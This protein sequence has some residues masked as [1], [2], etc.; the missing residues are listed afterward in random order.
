MSRG[1]QPYADIDPDELMNHLQENHRLIQPMNC[2]DSLYAI[3]TIAMHSSIHLLSFIRRFKIMSFCWTVS[4]DQRPS[5]T[6]LLQSLMEFY[7][8]LARFI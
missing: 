6:S 8:Q 5:M 4:I 7:G 2:P 3:M 1:L